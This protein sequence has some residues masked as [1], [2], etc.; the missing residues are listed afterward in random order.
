MYY[1]NDEVF[2]HMCEAYLAGTLYT[3]DFSYVLTGKSNKA[4]ENALRNYYEE[5]TKKDSNK[6]NY[7]RDAEE[8]A[9]LLKSVW[10][11][12]LHKK[13]QRKIARMLGRK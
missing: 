5:R 3:R 11:E 8:L 9:S 6:K 13:A 4:I 12:D 1:L 2:T 10:A 7:E